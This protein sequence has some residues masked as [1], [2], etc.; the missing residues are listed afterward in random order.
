MRPVFRTDDPLRVPGLDLLLRP[1][2][3]AH[4]HGA[5]SSSGTPAQAIEVERVLSAN[6]RF[7]VSNRLDQ[8]LFNI[9]AKRRHSARRG[10]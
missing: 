1:G 9:Q 4:L 3:S 7:A 5:K 2:S 10:G 6:I 8:I